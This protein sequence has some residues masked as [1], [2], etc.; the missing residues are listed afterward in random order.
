MTPIRA[1]YSFDG[2]HSDTYYDETAI[3]Y[4]IEF[5]DITLRGGETTIAPTGIPADRAPGTPRPPHS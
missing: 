5:L 3:G 2:T 1:A 4:G